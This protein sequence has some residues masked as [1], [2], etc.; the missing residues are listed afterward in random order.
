MFAKACSMAMQFTQPVITSTRCADGSVTSGCAAF[1]IL[2]NDGWI[3]TAG[4]VLASWLEFQKHTEERRVYE[5]EVKAI[6]ADRALTPKA[7][8]KRVKA[9][10]H[11]P[12]WI[13]NQSFWWGRDS[14]GVGDFTVDPV[15]DLGVAQL[16]PF[17]PS[18]VKAYPRLKDPSKPM[19][20]GTSL[21][22]LGFPFHDIPSSFDA[23][24]GRF[25]LQE[26]AL[27]VPFFPIEGIY[28]RNMIWHQADRIVQ[29]LET[30]SP[31]LRGQSGG[32]IF[33]VNGTVWALQS[34]TGHFPLGF[35]PKLKKGGREVEEHQFLNVGLGSHVQEIARFLSDNNIAFELADY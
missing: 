12:K 31:G 35:S 2:N 10:R 14:V 5:D 30:S 28:T 20:V 22:R 16:T 15:A 17:D 26:G 18:W 4:H 13:T 25:I 27:P 8:Q 21:C 24:T 34:R 33:D 23:T 1:V 11:N 32:P 19:A 3:L 29:F 9:L 7:K 6:Q